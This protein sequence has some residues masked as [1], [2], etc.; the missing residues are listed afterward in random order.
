[1]MDGSNHMHL[2]LSQPTEISVPATT[3]AEME[4]EFR[5]VKYVKIDAEG[6]EEKVIST[7]TR[8]IPL[9]SMEFNFPQMFE[10]LVACIRHLEAFGDYRFNAAISEPPAKFEFDEWSTGQEIVALI[11][12]SQMA[13]Y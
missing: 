4:A 10:A 1:M 3:L 9:I 13:I 8:P 5:P 6:F 11:Q 7:L 2:K 12:L